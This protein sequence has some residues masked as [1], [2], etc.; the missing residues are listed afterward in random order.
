MKADPAFL[1]ELGL[2]LL[3]LGAAGTLA[4]RVGL[5]AVP[6]FLLAGLMVGEGGCS[7]RRARHRSWGSPPGSGW[8]C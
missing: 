3:L 6:L 2:M 1:V 5:S 8:C 4:L 7:P